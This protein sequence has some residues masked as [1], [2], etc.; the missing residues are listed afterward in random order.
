MSKDVN[1]MDLTVENL[2][3]E[4]LEYLKGHSID[5]LNKVIEHI[6]N[7]D[8]ESIE[9][10]LVY[11]SAGDGYGDDNYYINFAYKKDQ[12]VDISDI[13]YQMKWLKGVLKNG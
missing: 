8:F 11:S 5:V 6:K 12:S 7:E 3:K 13:V 1:I 4:Q 2:A 9:A 10:M